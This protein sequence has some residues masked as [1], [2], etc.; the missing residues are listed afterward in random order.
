M[1]HGRCAL[2]S[3]EDELAELA[4]VLSGEEAAEE[5][6]IS[7][8]DQSLSLLR[9]SSRK[10]SYPPQ[11]HSSQQLWSLHLLPSCC[12]PGLSWALY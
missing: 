9:Y 6:Q 7:H 8:C 3:L 11:N 1:Y 2:R 5:S 12:I 4:L 10:K